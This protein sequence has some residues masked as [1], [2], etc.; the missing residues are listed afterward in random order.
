MMCAFKRLFAYMQKSEKM[1][2]DFFYIEQ[3][4]EEAIYTVKQRIT[5]P[6]DSLPAICRLA[7][8]FVGHVNRHKSAF[9]KARLNFFCDFKTLP[10]RHFIGKENCM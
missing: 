5:K 10:F 6:L 4:L 1:R 3:Q 9:R 7:C 2:N 8:A